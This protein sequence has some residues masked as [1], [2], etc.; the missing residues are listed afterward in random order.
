MSERKTTAGFWNTVALVAVL[1]G[2]PLSFGPACWWLSRTGRAVGFHSLKYR[3]AH[4]TYWPMGYVA[5]YGPRPVHNVI[6][7]YATVGLR[8]ETVVYLWMSAD[9]S[10]KV[11]LWSMPAP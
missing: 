7:W 5:Q 2:Y 10:E 11:A 8:N 9:Q 4:V 1:V 6:R 3:L